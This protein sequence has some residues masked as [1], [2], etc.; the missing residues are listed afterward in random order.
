[1]LD[2]R[3]PNLQIQLLTSILII[4]TMQ[5]MAQTQIYT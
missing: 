4:F 1:M 2:K 5:I 3:V